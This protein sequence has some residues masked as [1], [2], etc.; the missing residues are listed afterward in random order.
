MSQPAHPR[1]AADAVLAYA[2][3][4]SRADLDAALE[5]CQPDVVFDTVAF[6]AVARGR[7]EARRQFSAFFTAFPDYNVEVDGILAEGD[8]VA[9]HGAITATMAG[10][11]AGLAPTGKRFRVP[12]ACSWTVAD[13]LLA[14][15]QF[16]FDLHQMCEQLG[17]ETS[18]VSGRLV[19]AASASATGS[20][21]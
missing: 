15:E 7:D 2:E 10:P 21:V 8:A 19:A 16:F 18:A 14:H 13:G 9:A 11:L 6:R 3:A 5:L 4:K 12:F 17:L 1:R 20:D